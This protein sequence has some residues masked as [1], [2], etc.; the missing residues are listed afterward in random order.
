MAAGEA[1]ASEGPVRLDR[2]GGD[3]RLGLVFLLYAIAAVVTFVVRIRDTGLSGTADERGAKSQV[4]GS[5]E[6]DLVGGELWDRLRADGR[7]ILAVSNRP[8]ALRRADH[9]LELPGNS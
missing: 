7:T 1:G 5:I 3:W 6:E 8:L 9:V 2:R 4:V